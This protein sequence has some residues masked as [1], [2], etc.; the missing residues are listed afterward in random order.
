MNVELGDELNEYL[1]DGDMD[2][3][4]EV[5]NDLAANSDKIL[6]HGKRI[7]AIVDNLLELTRKAQAGEL[8]IDD[9][10]KHDF[11]K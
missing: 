11:S 3:V 4:K 2:G 5:A 7:A 8:E 1:T 9:E 10:N 6:E